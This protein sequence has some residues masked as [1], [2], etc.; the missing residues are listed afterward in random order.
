MTLF[1][2]RIFL[3]IPMLLGGCG[4][5]DPL[6]QGDTLIVSFQ[7]GKLI[8]PPTP[9]APSS[10]PSALESAASCQNAGGAVL[11]VT[12]IAADGTA[13]SS[14][15]VSLWMSSP[16]EGRLIPIAGNRRRALA[17][18]DAAGARAQRRGGL[19]FVRG[20]VPRELQ[21]RQGASRRD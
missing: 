3:L 21:P 19:R 7:P 14:A 10:F 16:S 5:P 8:V 15:Q 1:T 6:D 20:D 11:R 17:D 2:H 13:A 9:A 12:G 18:R 4:G